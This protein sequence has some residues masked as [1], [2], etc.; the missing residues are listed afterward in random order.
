[1]MTLRQAADIPSAH[2][3]SPGGDSAPLVVRIEEFR[4]A[5]IGR[6]SVER[7]FVG[8]WAVSSEE[9]AT[10]ARCKFGPF[11]CTPQTHGAQSW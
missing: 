3:S 1:M 4:K 6:N 8:L 7:V 5:F 2:K 10:G 9:G 11:R